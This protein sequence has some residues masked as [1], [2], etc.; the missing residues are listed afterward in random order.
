[1]LQV[2]GLHSGP[3]GSSAGSGAGRR[4]ARQGG[5][6]FRASAP[7]TPLLMAARYRPGPASRI[8]RSPPPELLGA[9]GQHGE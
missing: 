7:S 3:A 1:V 9:S 6:R 8:R 4:T 5:H 2:A